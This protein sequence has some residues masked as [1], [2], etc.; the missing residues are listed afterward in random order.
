MSLNGFLNVVESHWRDL[1]SKG[2]EFP[3][4]LFNFILDLIII[5]EIDQS[6]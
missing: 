2:G 4:C 3:I 1:I 5:Q 6:R